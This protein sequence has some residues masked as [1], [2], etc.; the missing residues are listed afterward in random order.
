M[1]AGLVW[2][3]A[4]GGAALMAAAGPAV[5]EEVTVKQALS[6][7]GKCTESLHGGKLPQYHSC[8]GRVFQYSLSDGSMMIMFAG[9]M[10]PY[11]FIGR[12]AS[13]SQHGAGRI[14]LT[15][16][17]AGRGNAYEEFPAKG[18]CRFENL[19]SGKEAVVSC[20]ATMSK[21]H[22]SAAFR[23]NGKP[24]EVVELKKG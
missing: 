6:V 12:G 21:G 9:A 14:T 10:I 4:L 7:R 13:W 18:Y 17:G 15:A 24:P 8:A 23:S 11:V 20:S 5:A 3:V 22:W 19:N 16:V 1:R 2:G